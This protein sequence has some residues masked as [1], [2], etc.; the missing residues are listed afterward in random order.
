MSRL[1]ERLKTKPELPAA[2]TLVV[3]PT[4]T[5]R[6]ARRDFLKTTAAV[7][8]G[9]CIAAYVPELAARPVSNATAGIRAASR[10]LVRRGSFGFLE[11]N[12]DVDED[13]PRSC[14]G[15]RCIRR[16][17]ICWKLVCEV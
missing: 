12:D 3:I 7:G 13:H 4:K 17:G 1:D 9:L 10:D 14:I 16:T 11:E 2:D 8:G 6:I 15:D 5:T